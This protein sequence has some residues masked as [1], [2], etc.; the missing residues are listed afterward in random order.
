VLTHC[1]TGVCPQLAD[2]GG[3]ITK[4]VLIGAGGASST[5]LHFYDMEG[6]PLAIGK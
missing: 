4:F 1:L 5:T 2:G 6:N 3:Y